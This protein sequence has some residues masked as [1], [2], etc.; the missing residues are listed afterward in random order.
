MNAIKII[1][2]IAI[3][4][5]FLFIGN[6]MHTYAHIPLPGSIIGLLLLFLV[7]S[8]NI[9]SVK[10][11]ERG[12]GFLLA[13]LPLLFVPTLVGIIKYPD[14][15]YGKG[16]LVLLVVIISTLMTIVSA[17]KISQFVEH[18]TKQREEKKKCYKRSSQSL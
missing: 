3:L 17:G 1:V 5:V 15:F 8:L 14:L 7:L 2:Q 18:K 11:I 6:A 16:L 9:L 4:Y 12:A 10:W 13:F